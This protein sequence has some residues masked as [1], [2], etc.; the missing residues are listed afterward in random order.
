MSL[1]AASKS[2]IA[3]I[4]ENRALEVGIA[5]L[6]PIE[7]KITLTQIVDNALYT[8]ST[9]FLQMMEVSLVVIS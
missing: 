3:C 9:A 7:S 4:M 5:I 1:A 8:H 6:Q 2:S